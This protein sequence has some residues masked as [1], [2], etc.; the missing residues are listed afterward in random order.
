MS[1][2]GKMHSLTLA[3]IKNVE[4]FREMN[5]NIFSNY[6]PSKTII[7]IDKGPPWLKDRIKVLIEKKNALYKGFLKMMTVIYV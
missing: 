1:L 4:I 2:T 3:F 5:L 6:Y 7:C